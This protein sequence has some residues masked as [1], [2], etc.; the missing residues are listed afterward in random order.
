VRRLLLLAALLSLALPSA[1][2]AK[3]FVVGHGQNGGIAI[4]D[5]GTVYVGWQVDVYGPG[6]AVQFCVVPPRATACG[7]QVTIPFPGKGY[8]ASRVSVLH[9]APGVIDVIEPRTTGS[10]AFTY[11]ARSTDG[12]RTFGPARRIAGEAFEGG[13]QAPDGRIALVSGPTTLT[14]G[15]FAPDGSS[16]RSRGSVLGPYLEGVFDDI[17]VSGGETL[18]AGSDATNTHAFRLPA[19]GDPNDAAAWQQIDPPPN[20][21]EPAV[22]GLPGGFAAML[23]PSGNG[24]DLFVQRL[25]GLGWSPPVNV[26]PAVGNF[27]FRLS[28][29]ARG[30]LTAAITQGAYHL[31]YSTS[32]DGGVLWSSV[33]DAVNW[34]HDLPDAMQVSTNSSGAGAAVV[35]LPFGDDSVRVARFTP[36]TS[37]VARRKLR[38][39][40]VQVRSI[41]DDGKLSLVVEAAKG[42]R[43]VKP[44]S[45][46]RK[47]RFGR[48]RGA[49]RRFRTRF[50]ARYVLH[51]RHARIPVRV[52]P[53]HG[54]ARTLRLRVR[55]CFRTS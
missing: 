36:R 4:D 44:S 7:S 18:G 50:R 47:A 28:S 39:R 33:V 37:P 26:A 38:G 48:A 13:V 34:G 43:Q 29:N 14:V 41:C 42:T 40:R 25:E 32:T 17:A 51:R 10:D 52:I 30:R 1:A 9:P 55:G 8:N 22:A 6:D 16:A 23:E 27:E 24:P 49:H 31:H 21:R 2:E 11:L 20:S 46:L 35:H 5:A 53:R 12:G 15:L 3:P 19:G 45:F 54:K